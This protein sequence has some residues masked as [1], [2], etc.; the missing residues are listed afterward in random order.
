M[1][2]AHCETEFTPKRNTGRFCSAKCRAAAWQAQQR[3][4]LSLTIEDLGH[5]TRRLERMCQRRVP[6]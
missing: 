1:R 6:R 2:C 5:A 4:E 3:R